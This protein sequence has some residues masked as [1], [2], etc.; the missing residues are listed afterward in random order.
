M[1]AR[2]VVG[3]LVIFQGDVHLLIPLYSVGVF[4]CFTLSQIGMVRHWRSARDAGWRWRAVVNGVGAI[5]TFTV[6]VVVASVKFSAGAWLVVVLIPLQVGI[7]LFINRQYRASATQL[8]I[9]PD[10]VVPAPHREERVV[11]PI[12]GLN[13]SVVQAIN[14]ARSIDDDVRAVFIT[15]DPARAEELREQWERQVPH[16][17]LVVVESPYRALAGPLIAYLDVLDR[18]FASGRVEDLDGM[19]VF[20]L[21][22]GP[23]R[24]VGLV[25]KRALDLVLSAVGLVLLSPVL[26][27]VALWI[28]RYDGGP[29]LFTQTRV[30]LHGRHFRCHKFRSM[31]IDAEERYHEVVA[32]SDPRAFKLDDDPRITPIGRFIR[33]TSLDEL[34]Q[35]W[36]VLRGEMSI[37]GPRP[38]PPREVEGYD[39]WHRRRLSMKPGITG[40]WQVTARQDDS[41]ERRATLDLD[42][43]D[44]WSLWLDLKIIAKTVP[45]ALEGR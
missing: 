23:D 17:P 36:N 22:S 1:E 32:L 35:L 19:P 25:A 6:L 2:V 42:Y 40:L 24:L 9:R 10:V 18:A 30:G 7:F 8:A 13:R 38:A 44:R 31:V 14:V 11:V 37:V 16:V 3:I 39:I 15:E 12:P 26:A 27:G 34:P 5:L 4:V 20:S 43:I 21:V 28:K 45:A 29:A 41:F 33:K